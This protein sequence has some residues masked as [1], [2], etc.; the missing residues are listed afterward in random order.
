MK[1]IKRT[2]R[3][4]TEQDTL[5]KK[6]SKKLKISESEVIRRAVNINI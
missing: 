4:S 3:I 6:L 5:I 1:L 2:Y